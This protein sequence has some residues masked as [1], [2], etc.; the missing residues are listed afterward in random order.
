MPMANREYWERKLE[1][2]R[3]RDLEN[4]DKLRDLGWEI[5]TVWECETRDTDALAIRLR[6]FLEDVDR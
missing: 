2:N 6:Q 1:R 4:A 3:I 5:E